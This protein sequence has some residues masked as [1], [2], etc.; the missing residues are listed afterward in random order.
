MM[1]S[2]TKHASNDPRGD[3]PNPVELEMFFKP[4]MF[5]SMDIQ[6]TWLPEFKDR[7]IITGREFER[8]FP[9][10]YVL[11]MLALMGAFGWNDL[12]PL[13]IYKMIYTQIW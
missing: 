2:I 9:V 5:K 10:K 7:P 3:G 13:P 4:R 1:H 8:I 11:R 12:R 6:R